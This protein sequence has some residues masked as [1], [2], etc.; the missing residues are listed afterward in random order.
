MAGHNHIVYC[1]CLRLRWTA[2]HPTMLAAQPCFP[3]AGRKL[4]RL[5]ETSTAATSTATTAKGSATNHPCPVIATILCNFPASVALFFPTVPKIHMEPKMSQRKPNSKEKNTTRVQVQIGRSCPRPLAIGALIGQPSGQSEHPL[6]RQ[7][8]YRPRPCKRCRWEMD[9]D[10]VG[11][12]YIRD[13][14]H[15]SGAW[16]AAFHEPP[17]SGSGHAT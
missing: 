4:L 15:T 13:F 16:P 10:R 14:N 6:W 12:F 3:G 2:A 5:G 17:S 8:G 11:I 9:V 7:R 1:S